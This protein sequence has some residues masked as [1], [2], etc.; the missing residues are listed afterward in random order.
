MKEKDNEHSDLS[1]STCERWWR[2]PASIRA[3]AK[4]PEQKPNFYMAEG[5]VA[6]TVAETILRGMINRED[7]DIYEPIVGQIVKQDGHKVPITK[8]MIDAA[9]QYAD[10]VLD[11]ADENFIA[12]KSINIEQRVVVSEPR[13]LWGTSDVNMA[14]T[15]T[16]FVDDFKYGAG[17]YV[18]VLDNKQ[19]RYYALGAY[20][21]MKK[22]E[23]E[24]IQEVRVG[25]C[26]PRMRGID[27]E[28]I[29]I[30]DIIDF[31][32]ELIYRA[33]ETEKEDAPYNPGPWCVNHFCPVR[34]NC[35]AYA[36]Y[37]N[38]EVEV[39]LQEMA[40][41]FIETGTAITIAN[42]PTPEQVAR[43]YAA[44]P[45]VEDFISQIKDRAMALGMAGNLPGHKVVQNYGNR[46]LSV[47]ESEL[48]AL[49]NG[50]IELYEEPKLK[51]PAGIERAIKAYN[52]DRKDDKIDLSIMR[53]I[54]HKPP[55]K[56][57]LV[58]E[59]DPR[60]AYKPDVLEDFKGDVIDVQELNYAADI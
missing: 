10:Y 41:E 48:Q 34:M 54:A 19:L 31:E 11:T 33:K 60:P 23:R 47:D 9:Y 7:K 28:V 43:L 15:Y 40:A 14:S 53:S 51:T 58:E 26:Q 5:T 36:E 42:E 45:M 39:D 25:I 16:L 37:R 13:K 17:T 35:Q 59:G 55:T 49:L 12:F 46:V 30:G 56:L 1:P 27:N 57:A 38:K 50:K 20:R 2:C 6:H 52:R 22:P 21:G 8:E 3:V 44:I 18:P 32:A 29:P 4:L 24:K